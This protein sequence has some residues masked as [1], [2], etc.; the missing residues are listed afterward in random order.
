MK[1]AHEVHPVA[2]F[3][4]SIRARQASPRIYLR[5][6][7]ALVLTSTAL[8]VTAGRALPQAGS[9]PSASRSARQRLE[10]GRDLMEQRKFAEAAADFRNLLEAEPNSPLLYNLLGFC[11][12]QQG[13]RGE[14]VTY[15]RKALDLN[16]GFK[17]A[18]NNLGGIYLLEGRPQDA[19]KEF[20]AV[21]RIDPR[22]AQAYFNLARAELAT[23]QK[24]GGLEHLRKAH[25]LSPGSGPIA[26]AL[27]RLYLEEGQKQ[28]GRPLVEKLV[29]AAAV[30]VTSELELADLLLSYGM[31]EVAVEHLRRAQR[32]NPQARETL[33]ALAAD[34]FKKQDYKTA[35]EL[36]EMVGASMQN[37][38]GWHELVA[39]SHFKLGD[40]AP[41]VAE[42]QRAMDLDPRNQ[43]YVLELSEIFVTNNN[44]TAAITLL[45]S[46][47]KAFPNSARIWFG[48]GVAYLDEVHYSAAETALSKSLE[49]DPNLDLAYVVLCRGYNEAGKLDQLTETAQRLSQVNPKNPMGYYYQ[50]LALLHNPSLGAVQDEDVEKLLKKC[51]E[52]GENDPEPRYELAKLLMKE[53]KKDAALRELKRIVRTNPDFGPAHYQLSRFYREKGEFEQS[54][55]ERKLFE[56]ISAQEHVKA[57]TRMLVEIHERR[58]SN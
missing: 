9:S 56:R 15:F 31:E 18:H 51:I 32:I 29:N 5:P 42:L 17:P 58:S 43:D 11:A 54:E 13:L 7:L 55:A 16:R 37:S 49:L 22:D 3:L 38:A 12:L 33:Y 45:E 36:L 52:L 6:V 47:T 24:E 10:R 25:D 35:L 40:P 2:R 21:T 26:M 30:D 44:P 28:L 8:C 53:G 23:N 46:A 57:M 19:A 34:H 27:A 50:A 1:R 4:A 41:A 39:E 20:L 48:L 14:A